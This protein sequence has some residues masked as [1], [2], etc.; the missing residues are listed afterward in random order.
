[1]ER[2]LLLMKCHGKFNQKNEVYRPVPF[3]RLTQISFFLP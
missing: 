3:A 2:N 1:M